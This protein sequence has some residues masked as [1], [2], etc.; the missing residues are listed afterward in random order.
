MNA[1]AEGHY[2]V[3]RI[4][5]AA[6]ANPDAADLFGSHALIHARE[7]GHRDVVAVLRLWKAILDATE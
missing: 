1:S 2:E 6:G 5:L 3:V 4:L 7:S